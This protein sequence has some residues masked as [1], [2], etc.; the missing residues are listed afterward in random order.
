MKT[1]DVF[2]KLEALSDR[3]LLDRAHM[4]LGSS[5]RLI[6]ELIAHLGEVEERRL[7]LAAACS[8]MFVYCL[9]LGMTEDE[10]YRRIEVARLARRYPAIFP[11][12]ADGQLSI[13]VVALLKHHLSVENHLDLLTS[14]AGKTVAQT[15][16]L[17]AARFPR[18]DVPSSVRKLP[19]QRTMR[20][21][22]L[23]MSTPMKPCTGET[24]P[25]LT[26]NETE[27]R[28][29][30]NETEPRLTPNETEP[31]T[32]LTDERFTSDVTSST[33]VPASLAPADL[34][35]TGDAMSFASRVNSTR[36]TPQ[37]KPLPPI[38][39]QRVAPASPPCRIEPLSAQR[40]KV[41]LTAS[42]ELARKLELARGL[43]RHSHPGGELGPI[44]ERALDLLIE[45]LMQRRFGKR[46]KA[47][48]KRTSECARNADAE[49][50]SDVTSDRSS[51][52]AAGAPDTAAPRTSLADTEP[53]T[54]THVTAELAAPPSGATIS[55]TMTPDSATPDSAT[56]DSATPD[57]ATPDSA[58]PV[59][60]TPDSATPDSTDVPVVHRGEPERGSTSSYIC[61]ST[62]RAVVERD[63]LACSWVDEHG[64]RCG[65]RAWLEYDHRHPR[66]KGGGAEPDNVRLLCRQHNRYAAEREYGRRHVEHT[67][68][69]RRRARAPHVQ[70]AI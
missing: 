23:S 41:Q 4:M 5:R 30:S 25:R 17:I 69:E 24:E 19:E 3:Q 22:S 10:A 50:R 52:P 66:A 65:S 37:G 63:G 27:P 67:I 32:A 31:R 68:A 59:T 14:A 34:V 45:N 46:K 28:L 62:R 40:Y 70:P 61:R 7:H 2:W 8:S 60:A 1:H 48:F 53:A 58:T 33:E 43:M 12:L 56:P 29:T 55:V 49:P 35:R 42:A 21:P 6:A 57:S 39:S 13:S 18:P 9:K 26:S 20:Q 64:V 38:H 44:I 15:R 16:E 51:M 47:S 54:C 36:T 11:L